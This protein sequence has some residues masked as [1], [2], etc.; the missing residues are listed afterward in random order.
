[1]TDTITREEFDRRVHFGDAGTAS[2]L[3]D[4]DIA[5]WRQQYPDWKAK[6]WSYIPV[7][8]EGTMLRLEPINVAARTKARR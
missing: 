8:D 1:M 3:D 2:Q 4:V 7:S 5:R 6:Y